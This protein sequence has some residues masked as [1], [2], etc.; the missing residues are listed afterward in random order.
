[1]FRSQVRQMPQVWRPR[2]H[3]QRSRFAQW[4]PRRR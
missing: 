4:P 2:R 3:R 1:M